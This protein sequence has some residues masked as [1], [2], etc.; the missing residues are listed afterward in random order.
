[1]VKNVKTGECFRLDNLIKNHQEKLLAEVT[2]QSEIRDVVT[3]D[4]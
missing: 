2:R 1:M 3:A 4:Q